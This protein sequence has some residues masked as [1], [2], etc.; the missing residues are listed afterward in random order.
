MY[1]LN[2]SKFVGPNYT[3]ILDTIIWGANW[4]SLRSE[5]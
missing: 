1:A 5:T 4:V 3:K 2:S